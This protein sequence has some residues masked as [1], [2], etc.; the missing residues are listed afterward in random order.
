MAQ[1]SQGDV[2]QVPLLADGTVNL[3]EVLPSLSLS[4][5][6][7]ETGT[8]YS[9]FVGEFLGEPLAGK[10]VGTDAM[11]DFTLSIE[12]PTLSEHA[13]FLIALSVIDVICVRKGLRPAP[14]LWRET[15]KYND[16]TWEVSGSCADKND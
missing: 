1:P 14:V 7:F 10:M 4:F 13:N 12:A 8:F 16:R 9:E 15:A 6:I 2:V 5:P 11:P 3:D